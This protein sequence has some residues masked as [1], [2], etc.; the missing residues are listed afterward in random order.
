MEHVACGTCRACCRNNLIL[1]LPEDGDD[2]D[3]FTE[4][5]GH[6]L[7]DGSTAWVLKHKPNGDCAYL[8]PDGCLVHGHHPAVCRAFDCIGFYRSRT[9][10]QRRADASGSPTTKAILRAARERGA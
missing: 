2:L 1:L 8:G 3:L 5:V 6:T 10:R 7:P 9:R 4:K